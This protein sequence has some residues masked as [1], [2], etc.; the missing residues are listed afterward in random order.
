MK[1]K[2]LAL[3]PVLMSGIVLA[4][5]LQA[6]DTAW[7]TTAMVSPRDTSRLPSIEDPATIVK[8]PV[9]NDRGEK[10]GTKDVPARN[11]WPSMDQ[12]TEKMERLYDQDSGPDTQ[13]LRVWDSDLQANIEDFRIPQDIDQ[14]KNLEQQ[15]D[16]A[17]KWQP[18][19][20]VERKKIVTSLTR[21]FGNNAT[22]GAFQNG[23]F[24]TE[25]ETEDVKVDQSFSG[26]G[27]VFGQRL[28]VLSQ[29][30]KSD[31]KSKTTRSDI[32]VFDQNV[33]VSTDGTVRANKSFTRTKGAGKT[34]VLGIIPVRVEGK[35]SGSMGANLD[36]KAEGLSIKGSV[37]PFINTKGTAS[38]GVDLLLVVA[39]IEGSL[40][41]IN[42]TLTSAFNAAVDPLE[43]E[44]RAGLKVDHKINLLSGDI[45]V[46]AKIRRLLR[47][48]KK[49]SKSIFSFKGVNENRNLINENIVEAL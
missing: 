44:L 45:S 10:I 34:F 15:E 6:D 19:K 46:F 28:T 11:V 22:F 26:G 40:T 33:F 31:S 23:G 18:L 1:S 20:K 39:G 32:K 41:F 9:L 48:D 37:A 17:K 25:G 14:R 38:A 13:T 43:R 24:S 36:Y 8:F 49:F 4:G 21:T 2:A 7:R 29:T 42:T 30:T 5:P 35:V 12:W 16:A 27:F 3:M 47:R